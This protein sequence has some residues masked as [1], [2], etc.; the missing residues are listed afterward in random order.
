MHDIFLTV[1]MKFLFLILE[2]YANILF[3]IYTYY[4]Q[5]L[6]AIEKEIAQ[7]KK[8]VEKDLKVSLCLFIHNSLLHV[9]WQ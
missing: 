1:T 5:F 7:L 8:P 4:E 9:M 2:S 6:P 3:N